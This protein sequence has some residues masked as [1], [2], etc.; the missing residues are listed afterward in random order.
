MWLTDLWVL[1]SLYITNDIHAF[2]T[3]IWGFPMILPKACK[4]NGS[5]HI[6]T[7]YDDIFIIL[8]HHARLSRHGVK[9]ATDTQEES[10]WQHLLSRLV[11]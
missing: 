4:T 3:A 5:I 11:C 2:F 6:F 8:S 1:H 9:D 10:F 7:Y